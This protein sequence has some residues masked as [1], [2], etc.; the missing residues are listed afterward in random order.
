LVSTGRRGRCTQRGAVSSVT[1]T[2]HYATVDHTFTGMTG[3]TGSGAITFSIGSSTSGFIVNVD[4][5][6]RGIVFNLVHVPVSTR[7]VRPY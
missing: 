4:D 2:A 7:A 6:R 5:R 1:V 3:A